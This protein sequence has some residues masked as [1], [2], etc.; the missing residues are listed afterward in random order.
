MALVKC[1]ECHTEVSTKASVCPK[2]SY[3]IAGGGTTQTHGG[4]V[5]TI[6]VTG[7]IYKLQQL[8]S[9]FLILGC[10]AVMIAANKG[11]DSINWSALGIIGGMIWFI[12][13]RFLIWWH[14]R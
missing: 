7:K 12:M 10:I 4:M 5:Q 14:H 9:G 3:P 1:P 8:L 11:S 6:E 13:V 2:C